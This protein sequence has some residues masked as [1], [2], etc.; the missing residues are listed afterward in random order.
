MESR[1]RSWNSFSNV[2]PGGKSLRSRS[3]SALKI[4]SSN[5]T[6]IFTPPA[7]EYSKERA[8]RSRCEVTVRNDADA[9]SPTSATEFPGAAGFDAGVVVVEPAGVSAA[10]LS[11]CVKVSDARA[12][13][14]WVN[15]FRMDVRFMC[16]IPFPQRGKDNGNRGDA[17]R[18]RHRMC[19]ADSLRL[20][21]KKPH[22]P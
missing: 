3:G 17:R 5:P 22:R 6:S 20:T 1:P 8:P 10:G 11:H 2:K 16:A 19:R 9:P 18:A 13:V 15:R 12:R 7:S 4:S 14:T 21:P